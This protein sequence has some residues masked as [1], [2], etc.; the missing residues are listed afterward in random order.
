MGYNLFSG[1][2]FFIMQH[3]IPANSHTTRM[4]IISIMSLSSFLL[5]L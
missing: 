3:P 2:I 4:Q 1:S 5:S